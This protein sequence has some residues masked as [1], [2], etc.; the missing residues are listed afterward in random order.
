MKIAIAFCCFLMLLTS[1]TS[2]NVSVGSRGEVQFDFGKPTTPTAGP[3]EDRSVEY[4]KAH[5]GETLPE[6]TVGVTG[7]L[8][9]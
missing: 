8:K 7:R 3:T 6:A 4:H 2:K 5:S 9:F 1:C